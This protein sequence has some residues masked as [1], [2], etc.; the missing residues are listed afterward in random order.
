MP[1]KG[2]I[3]WWEEQA[4]ECS[5]PHWA[6]LLQTGEVDA[7]TVVEWAAGVWDEETAEPL[8]WQP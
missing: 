8:A 4:S 7:A 5:Q 2:F 6:Y 1:T 3:G